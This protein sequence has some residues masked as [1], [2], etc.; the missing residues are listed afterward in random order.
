[1]RASR[2]IKAH[3]F[4]SLCTSAEDAIGGKHDAT[5]QYQECAGLSLDRQ[6]YDGNFGPGLIR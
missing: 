3:R 5:D 6:R 4:C 2:E 1:M